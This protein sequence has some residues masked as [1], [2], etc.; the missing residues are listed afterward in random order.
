MKI[1]EKNMAA[2]LSPSRCGSSAGCLFLAFISSFRSQ[3][4]NIKLHLGLCHSFT[5]SLLRYR[6][7]DRGSSALCVELV[8]SGL[9]A[10]S[11]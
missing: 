11:D 8:L 2:G 1:Q 7:L 5:F 3:I 6:S 10:G 4:G 9:T